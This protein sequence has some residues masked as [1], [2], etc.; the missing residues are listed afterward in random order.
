MFGGL[1]SSSKESSMVSTLSLSLEYPGDAM[2]LMARWT[3]ANLLPDLTKGSS[4]A[5]F[6]ASN[7][8]NQH[9]K[10]PLFNMKLS[11]KSFCN[12]LHV[13]ELS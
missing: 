6:T 4:S 13:V 2:I 7:A 12:V 3:R 9:G 5:C 11:V 10:H 1:G 8:C